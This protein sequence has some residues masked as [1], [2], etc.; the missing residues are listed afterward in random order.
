MGKKKLR[1]I[2]VDGTAYL[3]AFRPGYIQLDPSVPDY[4]CNDQFVAYAEGYKRN[5][6]RI[7]FITWEC[8]I[9]G[10]P[11]RDGGPLL[12][13]DP[14][15]LRA[16][17]HTPRWAASLIRLALRQ[18]WQAQR[19]PLTLENGTALLLANATTLIE[20]INL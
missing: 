1:E 17:L 6:V 10:G 16:N 8:P 4:L 18:G 19:A 7:R 11:L 3:W 14:E 2:I 12:L 5:L 20:E 15:S 13:D 9:S